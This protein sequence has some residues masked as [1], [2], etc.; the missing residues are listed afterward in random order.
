MAFLMLGLHFFCPWN[1]F[2]DSHYF[3]LLYIFVVTA[4]KI[5]STLYI[6]RNPFSVVRW[7]KLRTLIFAIHIC[8]CA[9]YFWST[10]KLFLMYVYHIV[11]FISFQRDWLSLGSIMSD[12]S[13][14]KLLICATQVYM[15]YSFRY[16]FTV[17]VSVSQYRLVQF[18]H[19][20]KSLFPTVLHFD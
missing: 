7:I 9:S 16:I 14:F 13:H 6:E 17:T 1:F 4:I 15:L 8:L 10:F 12:F 11:G 3:I 19:F 20:R 18:S 5:S 2:P